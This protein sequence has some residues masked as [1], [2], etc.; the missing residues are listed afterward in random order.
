MTHKITPFLWYDD[1]A[2]EAAK[3]YVETL[4]N[5]E[6]LDVQRYSEVGSNGTGKVMA[7]TFR[8]GSLEVTAFNGGP[9]YKHTP[10][11]SFF[12]ECESEEELDTAWSRLSEGA[13]VLMP[14][15]EYP[16]SERFGWLND[17]FGLSWQLSLTGT[18]Q[19]VTPFLMFVG[20]AYGKSGEAAAFYT[21]L[22]EHSRIDRVVQYGEAEGEP[23]GSV[24]V[25]S[26][27]VAGLPLRAM[28]SGAPHPF[29]FSPAAS[30]FIR[31]EDQAEID[32]LWDA[33]IAGGKA[34]QCGWLDDRYGVTWQ[35]ASERLLELLR[36][37]DQERVRRVTAALEPMEKI[38]LP[39]L[40]RAYAGE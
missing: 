10:A 7:V 28:D 27:T 33:L 1:N 29:T 24:A 17:R 13:A 18:P 30:L 39:A 40:E 22:F 35:V 32:R 21:S 2:D 12:V 16:F 4:Q 19:T 26:L 38:D 37:P 36:D 3:L 11:F 8:L 25:T 5:A 14:L 31:C 6:L 15:A 9:Y 34:H 20:D 23:S